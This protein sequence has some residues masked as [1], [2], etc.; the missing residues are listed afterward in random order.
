MTKP[1][2]RIAALLAAL[3]GASSAQAEALRPFILGNPPSG[4]MTQTVALVSASLVSQGFSLV[5]TYSP[6]PKATVICVTNDELK[7]AAAATRNGGFGVVERVAVTEVDGKLQVS[8]V[9]PAYMGVAY[10]MG[11]LPGVTEKMVKALGRVKDFGSEDGI[12]DT[13]LGPGQWHYMIGMPYF[14]QVDVLARYE[15]HAAAVAA[16]EKSLAAGKEGVKKVYRVDV[17]DKEI[18]VF[19]VSLTEGKGAEKWYLPIVDWQ[20]YRHTA[21]LPYEMMVQGDEVISQRG[22]YRIALYWPDTSMA[23]EHG[24]TKLM[25]VPGAIKGALTSV[26]EGM[27]QASGGVAAGQ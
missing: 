12:E 19:G 25:P 11:K 24:F 22:R 23:G 3:M 16:V 18:V 5:G 6:I 7:A 4:N 8:Y 17:P 20:E 1:W 27:P 21:F 9:N 2:L 15:N 13:K 26:A 10:G 14:H